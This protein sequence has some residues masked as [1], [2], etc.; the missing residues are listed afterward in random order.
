MLTAVG[1]AAVPILPLLD[2]KPILF[3]EI[4]LP[5]AVNILPVVIVAVKQNEPVEALAL[6]LFSV[7]SP[8]AS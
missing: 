2:D 3:A 1:E 4:V 7:M 8:E 6:E 5:T